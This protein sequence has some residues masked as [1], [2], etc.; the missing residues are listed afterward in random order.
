MLEAHQPAVI[1]PSA[2]TM[3]CTVR[4]VGT[5]HASGDPGLVGT[6]DCGESG[7]CRRGIRMR[8]PKAPQQAWRVERNR[9]GVVKRATSVGVRANVGQDQT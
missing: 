9:D 1:M 2:A 6:G 3:G 5:T 8:Q 4:W 7:N